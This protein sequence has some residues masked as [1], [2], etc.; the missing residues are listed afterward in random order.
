VF[1]IYSVWFIWRWLTRRW[2]FKIYYR[3]TSVVEGSDDFN[4]EL[5]SDESGTY[6]YTK[7]LTEFCQPSYQ[8]SHQ[9]RCQLSYHLF[10]YL[11]HLLR[12]CSDEEDKLSIKFHTDSNS[13]AENAYKKENQNNKGKFIEALTIDQGVI[14]H[15]VLHETLHCVKTEKCYMVSSKEN[16]KMEFAARI[17]H[18]VTSKS[19]RVVQWL[20]TLYSKRRRLI[21]TFSR[22]R[23]KIFTNVEIVVL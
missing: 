20:I 17:L 16:G 15:L 1:Q 3:N 11:R 22:L 5:Q 9:L 8:L 7:S 4:Y 6:G 2:I 19:L 14:Q 21:P 18:L 12:S 13:N 10:H 23:S